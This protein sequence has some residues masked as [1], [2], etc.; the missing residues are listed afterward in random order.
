MLEKEGRDVGVRLTFALRATGRRCTW[1]PRAGELTAAS[2]CWRM[3]PTYV[4][5]IRTAG[6]W[7]TFVSLDP[8]FPH[9]ARCRTPLHATG[10]KGTLSLRNCC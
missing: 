4:L 2:C 1:R 3:A 8:L 6:L 5:L 9:H 10:Q 7:T